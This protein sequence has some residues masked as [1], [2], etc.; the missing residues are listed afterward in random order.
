MSLRKIF[1]NTKHVAEVIKE[2]DGYAIR[3]LRLGGLGGIVIYAK[4]LV[5]VRSW[6]DIHYPGW[7]Q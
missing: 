3:N 7:T 6:L 5:E 4:S 2:A 1:Y